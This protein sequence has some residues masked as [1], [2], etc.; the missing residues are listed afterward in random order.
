MLTNSVKTMLT[1]TAI[2]QDSW[3]KEVRHTVYVPTMNCTHFWHLR[4]TTVHTG[5]QGLCWY[6]NWIC[7]FCPVVVWLPPQPVTPVVHS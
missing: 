6:W 5:F 2:L 1:R 7:C 3:S 4:C